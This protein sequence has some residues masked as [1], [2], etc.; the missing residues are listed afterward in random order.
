MNLIL[1]QTTNNGPG[2]RLLKVINTLV[3]EKQKEIYTT[4]NSLAFRLRQTRYD[5]ALAVLL[6]TSRKELL[7]ILSLR[8]LLLDVRIILI[9]PDREYDTVLKG[10]TLY[11]RFLSYADSDFKDV[12]AVLGKM[13]NL[14]RI[15]KGR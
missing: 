13:L 15:K 7:D 5:L 14:M 8:D 12:A 10:H 9:L 11:P 4:I 3:P 6:T 1:Y 2:E